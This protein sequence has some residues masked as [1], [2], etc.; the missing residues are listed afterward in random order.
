VAQGAI[1]FIYLNSSVHQAL[2]NVLRLLARDLR[3]IFYL[4]ALERCVGDR[5]CAELILSKRHSS[6]HVL[7]R[8]DRAADFDPF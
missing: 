2:E 1:G 8:G 4:V 6:V 3:L 7:H 5:G